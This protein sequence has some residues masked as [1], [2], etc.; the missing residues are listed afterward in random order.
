MVSLCQAA[1]TTGPNI[2]YLTNP[3]LLLN[4]VNH[5]LLLLINALNI[6]NYL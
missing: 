4:T 2:D 5:S 1:V 6:Y 3:D